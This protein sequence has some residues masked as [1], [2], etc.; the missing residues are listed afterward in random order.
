MRLLLWLPASAMHLS[1]C[2]VPMRSVVVREDQ[3]ISICGHRTP[4]DTK[5]SVNAVHATARHL[6]NVATSWDFHG[7]YPEDD[8]FQSLQETRSLLKKGA[9]S[10]SPG[11]CS[12]EIRTELP[13]PQSPLLPMFDTKI[14]HENGG[15]A[16]DP[17]R[18][19]WH[20][21]K[22]YTAPIALL[23]VGF[24]GCYTTP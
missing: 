7:G 17:L 12:L 15:S 23:H 21:K 8:C 24:K 10:A 4:A 13:P 2:A 22:P 9:A 11:E 1:P 18:H 5:A 14:H 16:V 20:L 6:P 3:V 19:S